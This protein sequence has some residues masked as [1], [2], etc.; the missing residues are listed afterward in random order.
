[1]GW[2]FSETKQTYNDSVHFDTLTSAS[3]I[4]SKTSSLPC[5]KMVNWVKKQ[6]INREAIL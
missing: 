2:L 6:G 1:M 5:L 3:K 4:P